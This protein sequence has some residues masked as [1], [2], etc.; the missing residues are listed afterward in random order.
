MKILHL[1]YYDSKGGAAI[2]VNRIHESL[3]LNGVDSKILVSEK[4]TTNSR[5][6]GP[7]STFDQIVSLLKISFQRKL[8]KINPQKEAFSRSFNLLSSNILNKINTLNPD[9]VHLHWIGNEMISIKQI[10]RINKPIVWTL[11]DM[12][13]YCAT[14]HYTFSKKYAEGYDKEFNK[15]FLNFDKYAWKLKKKYL[16]KEI[17]FVPTSEWQKKNLEESILFKD[18]PN[19]LIPL[20][21]DLNFWKPIDKNISKK[22]LGLPEDKKIILLGGDQIIKRKWK[23]F[24]V[25]KDILSNEKNQFFRDEIFYLFFGDDKEMLP[26]LKNLNIKYKY[27]DHVAPNSYDIKL[28]YSASDVLLIPSYLESFGQIA[29]EA[30][31]CGTPSVCFDKTGVTE[32]VQHLK[33]GY[34]AK[35]NDR[36]DF[37]KGIF[38]CLDFSNKK[39]LYDECIKLAKN[40]FSYDLISEEYIKI[41][42][43]LI[44]N[45]QY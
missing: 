25:I 6:I 44:R 38:W 39:N 32:V 11:H 41:Y 35:N 42:K 28:L 24:D 14:E 2:A 33:T 45:N 40:K 30:L 26:N 15:F 17:F 19:K 8:I 9:L 12:W 10:S 20:P 21:L 13:P 31:S 34:V 22:I 43:S 37:E 3:I 29:L 16:K 27:F 4:N 36:E 18:N 1:N 5:I 23:G 7:L